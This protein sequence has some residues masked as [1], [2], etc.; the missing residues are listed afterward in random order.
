[1]DPWGVPF[2]NVGEAVG[3]KAELDTAVAS[4]L[5]DRFARTAALAPAGFR[6]RG[7]TEFIHGRWLPL[8][9]ALILVLHRRMDESKEMFTQEL[10]R[11]AVG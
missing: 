3:A 4:N 8:V 6:H 11:V 1:M 7:P 5:K 10:A 9:V 2:R